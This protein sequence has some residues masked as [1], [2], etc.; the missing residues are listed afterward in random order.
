VR[1]IQPPARPRAPRVRQPHAVTTGDRQLHTARRPRKE[2]RRTVAGK[3]EPR[4]LSP[5]ARAPTRCPNEILGTICDGTLIT[6]GGKLYREGKSPARRHAASSGDGRSINRFSCNRKQLPK[7]S[8]GKYPSAKSPA[9][10]E[11]SSTPIRR[12]AHRSRRG[13]MHGLG[14]NDD[15]C[16][17][18]K[19][20]PTQ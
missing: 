12:N 13:E 10:I 4:F 8:S 20:L 2:E 6:R 16:S 17:S 19:R 15:S 7:A 1:D 14:P 9:A 18:P 3:G 11:G 5:S